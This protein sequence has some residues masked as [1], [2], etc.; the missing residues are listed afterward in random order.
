MIEVGVRARGKPVICMGFSSIV[1]TTPAGEME[2]KS[3]V[4]GLPKKEPPAASK[5]SSVF[6]PRSIT[7][8]DRGGAGGGDAKQNEQPV[9]ALKLV[10]LVLVS[11]E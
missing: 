3:P 8:L 11:A 4:V 1:D 9:H 2:I 7:T 5:F 6:R 10:H